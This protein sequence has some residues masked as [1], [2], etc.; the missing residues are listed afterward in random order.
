M[1]RLRMGLLFIFTE[2]LLEL[3]ESGLRA[4]NVVRNGHPV[5]FNDSGRVQVKYDAKKGICLRSGLQSLSTRRWTHWSEILFEVR[6]QGFATSV[7]SGV[8]RDE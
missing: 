7:V 4:C 3:L 8:C 5:V 6:M 2:L 1:N